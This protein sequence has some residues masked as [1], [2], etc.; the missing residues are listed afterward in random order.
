MT[1]TDRDEK[2]EANY[3]PEQPEATIVLA[4]ELLPEMLPILPIRP[5]PLFPGLPIPLEIGPEQIPTVQHAM[6]HASKTI[7]VVLVR[8]LKGSETPENMHK[9]GVAAKILKAFQTEGDVPGILISCIERFTIKDIRK[10]EF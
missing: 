5:R 1:E 6:E 3:T 2:N 9:V 10:A 4:S 7:G 8:D